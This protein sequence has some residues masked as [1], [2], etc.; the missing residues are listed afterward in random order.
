MSH[1]PTGKISRLPHQIREE[2]HSRLRNGD[3]NKQILASLNA[4]PEV[5]QRVAAEF[6][7]HSLSPANL[8]QWKK[9]HHPAWLLQQAALSQASRFLSQSRQLAQ[10]G[11]GTVTDNLAAFVAAQ[12]ALATLQSE[13]ERDPAA[14]WKKLRALCHDVLALRRSDQRAE[15]LRLQRQRPQSPQAKKPAT[16]EP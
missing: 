10:A 1:S 13:D 16:T 12:Y 6:A 5:Q 9:R 14:S 7:G 8:S 11:D 4:I 2:I 3:R 15:C